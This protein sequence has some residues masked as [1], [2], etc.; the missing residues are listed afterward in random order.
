MS[1]DA[2]PTNPPENSPAK[3]YANFTAPIACK[4]PMPHPPGAWE[5]IAHS[6]S[7]FSPRPVKMLFDDLSQR[8]RDCWIGLTFVVGALW[9]AVLLLGPPFSNTLCLFFRSMQRQN[10]SGCTPR[11]TRA[12]HK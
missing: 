9:G 1:T 6:A 4:M 7:P 10:A 2:T 12:R 8:S 11:P 5:F 3:S